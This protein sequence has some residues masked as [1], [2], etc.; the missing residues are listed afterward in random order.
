MFVLICLLFKC[1]AFINVLYVI[2]YVN[3]FKQTLKRRNFGP[4]FGPRFG[5]RFE[6]YFTEHVNSKV[7]ISGIKL[8]NK[9]KIFK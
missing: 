3:R 7:I 5:P 8:Y 2:K 1:N 9:Y 6:T 4:F